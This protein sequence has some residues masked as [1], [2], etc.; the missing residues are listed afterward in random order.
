MSRA[1][2]DP[3]NLSGLILI[4]SLALACLKDVLRC[5]LGFVA[6]ERRLFSGGN[7]SA[8]K[9]YGVCSGVLG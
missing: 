5:L 7:K 9:G 3:Q 1:L 4:S 2:G 8:L 6:R